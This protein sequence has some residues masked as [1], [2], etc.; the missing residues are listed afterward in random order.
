MPPAAA[1]VLVGL[2][3]VSDGDT[4]RVDGQPIRLWGI[5]APEAMQLCTRDGQPYACG[6]EATV[7]LRAIVAGKLVTCTERTRDRW[8]RI[9]AVSIV[10]GV[11]IGAAMIESGYA[12]SSS[13]VATT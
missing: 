1:L 11:D 6:A 8:Q 12:R 4:L 3:M 5:D 10:D 9:V 13:T 7:H 2:A